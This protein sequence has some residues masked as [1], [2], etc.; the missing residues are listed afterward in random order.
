MYDEGKRKR[1]VERE[2]GGLYNSPSTA[3]LLGKNGH[4]VGA[5]SLRVKLWQP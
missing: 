2:E 3:P 4:D 5:V 1:E